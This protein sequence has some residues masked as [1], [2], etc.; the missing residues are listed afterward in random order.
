MGGRG[1]VI[2]NYI[3]EGPC[4]KGG[5]RSMVE[6]SGGETSKGVKERHPSLN[7]KREKRRG[8]GGKRSKT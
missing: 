4:A 2:G 6:E 5:G 8:P 7:T 3:R 1:K